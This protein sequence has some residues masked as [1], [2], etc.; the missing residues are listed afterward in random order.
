MNRFVHHIT[1]KAPFTVL[2]KN[3][4][5][6]VQIRPFFFLRAG[7]IMNTTTNFIDKKG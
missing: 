5:V 2:F 3:V 7:A 6:G 4:Q 1:Y